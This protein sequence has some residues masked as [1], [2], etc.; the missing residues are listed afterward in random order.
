MSDGAQFSDLFVYVCHAQESDCYFE[1]FH[2]FPLFINRV[3]LNL[4][5]KINKRQKKNNKLKKKQ[6]KKLILSSD[7]FVIDRV[8]C[9]RMGSFDGK[10]I[11]KSYCYFKK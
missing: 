4:K 2:F 8:L 1:N 5:K 11:W 9:S 7:F 6:K 10:I 3:Q